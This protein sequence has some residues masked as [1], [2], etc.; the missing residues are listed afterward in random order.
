MARP[1]ITLI[2]AALNPGPEVRQTLQ[3]VFDQSYPAL[4]T[5][6]VDGGSRP[7]HF[8][9]VEPF[10][11]RIDR[12]VREP[13][14][15]ISDAWNKALALADGDLIGIVSAD[16]YLLPGALHKVAAAFLRAGSTGIVH[17][18]ALHLNGSLCTRRRPR[19]PLAWALRVGTPVIHPA[20]FVARA[21]YAS[22]GGFDTRCRIA[23]DYDFILRAHLAGTSFSYLPEP[24]V[25]YRA[26]GL[27][28]RRPL[29]GFREVRRS[30][31]ENGYQR[32]LVELLHAAKVGVRRYIRPLLSRG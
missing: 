5:I 2:T 31:L 15:G 23:M 32:P 19:K 21:V 18:D 28:D 17:G 16:D 10:L 8:A 7:E 29:G 3:S 11:N 4:Q 12:V 13:D 20:T 22:V 24:L 1:R 25:A 6:F 26:G 9:H 27:S 30:Q 14:D